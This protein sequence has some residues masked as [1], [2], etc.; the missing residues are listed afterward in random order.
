MS[1][2]GCA[3]GLAVVDVLVVDGADEG[4]ERGVSGELAEER[5]A[6]KW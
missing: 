6:V 1:V 4:S 3:A 5:A 2:W